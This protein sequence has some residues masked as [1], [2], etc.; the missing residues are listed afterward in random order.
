MEEEIAGDKEKLEKIFQKEVKGY[1]YPFGYER[2]KV[3]KIVEKAGF[4]YSRG[5]K[6]THNFL[7]P[8]NF[9]NLQPTCSHMDRDLFFLLNKFLNADDEN[10]YL[11]YIWGHGYEFDYNIKSASYDRIKRVISMVATRDDVICCSNGEAV[12]YLY[13]KREK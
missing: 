13:D 9:I 8:N 11:F 10:D 3:K 2:N 4:K 12:Q 5:I 6:N 7:I 1:V